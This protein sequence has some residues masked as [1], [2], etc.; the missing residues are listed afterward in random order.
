M[1][2]YDYH[3]FAMYCC[4]HLQVGTS[5]GAALAAARRV[6][7]RTESRDKL[8]VTVLA[9]CGER[10]LSTRMY[11]DLWTASSRPAQLYGD[12]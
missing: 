11:S 12:L 7:K 8:V 3:P 1:R 4:K 9:S 2:D 10:Y 5:S 6:A